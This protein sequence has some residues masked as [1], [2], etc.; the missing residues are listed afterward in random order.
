[1]NNP[2]LTEF[3]IHLRLPEPHEKVLF[4]DFDGVVHPIRT[5]GIHAH[6][7]QVKDLVGLE[8]FLEGKVEIVKN[9]CIQSN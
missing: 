4:L 9:I 8:I 7:K 6:W 3:K 2:F 5:A 1:M